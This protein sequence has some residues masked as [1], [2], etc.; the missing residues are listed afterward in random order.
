MCL[1]VLA[2]AVAKVRKDIHYLCQNCSLELCEV[3]VFAAVVPPGPRARASRH[4]LWDTN[5]F[6]S[7]SS[8]TAVLAPAVPDGGRV[9]ASGAILA[10]SGG[11]RYP[12]GTHAFALLLHL[13]ALCVSS[14]KCP[15]SSVKACVRAL[16]P[17]LCGN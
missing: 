7:W 3:V 15:G 5:Y 1:T 9:R 2:T 6:S 14:P 16:F 13:C 4:C 17:V 8:E 10:V 12:S 11:Y